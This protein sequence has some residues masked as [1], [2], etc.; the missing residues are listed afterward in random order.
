MILYSAF[1]PIMD[2]TEPLPQSFCRTEKGI[3]CYYRKN[4]DGEPEIMFSTDPERYLKRGTP[5]Q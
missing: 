1:P 5:L 2:E 4:G 3:P